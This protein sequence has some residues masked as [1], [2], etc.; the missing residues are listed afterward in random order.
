M[1]GC[2]VFFDLITGEEIDSFPFLLN[3]FT[4]DKIDMFGRDAFGSL[5]EDTDHLLQIII[6]IALASVPGIKCRADLIGPAVIGDDLV[7]DHLLEDFRDQT[8]TVYRSIYIKKCSYF[9]HLISSLI[10]S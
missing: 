4:G 5:T 9:L 10:F 1:A 3:D 2:L 6:I 8:F 7:G